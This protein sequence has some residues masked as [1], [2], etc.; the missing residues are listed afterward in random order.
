MLDTPAWFEER[1]RRVESVRLFL[2]YDGT[3]A[4][5]APTPDATDPDP[6]V[7]GLVRRLAQQP[8]LRVAVISGRRLAHLKELLPGSGCLL[9]GTYGIEWTLPEGERVESLD[10]TAIRPP[11]EGLKPEWE[12]IAAR[13][14]G[15]YL[16]DKGWSLALHARFA[17]ESDAEQTMAEARQAVA[18]WV[19]LDSPDSM[20]RQHGG[21][22]FF[23]ICPALAHK[24]RAVEWLL[25]HDPWPG[26]LPVYM[27][28]D[29]NDEDAFEAIHQ[30]RGLAILVSREPRSTQADMRLENPQAARQWL[31]ELLEILG[32][33]K[34][35]SPL[36]R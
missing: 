32:G 3:L 8:R 34:K 7:V 10:L 36:V 1:L 26:G 5:F 21:P 29:Y 11:L 14:P 22:R 31:E 4:E 2:D 12:A 30:H 25:A 13:R 33:E 16:E 6:A 35:D 17:T 23:E 20:F 18:R 28:D 27:G 19:D 24:G 15:I 9:A